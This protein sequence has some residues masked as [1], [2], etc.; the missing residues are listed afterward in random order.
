MKSSNGVVGK[1]YDQ[2]NI[3]LKKHIEAVHYKIETRDVV[4]IIS[5]KGGGQNNRNSRQHDAT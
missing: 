2:V 5:D 1:M 3:H 4:I